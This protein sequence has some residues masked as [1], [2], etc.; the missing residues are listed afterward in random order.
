MSDENETVVVERGAD[1]ALVVRARDV[2]LRV[3]RQAD[4]GLRSVELLLAGLGS[5]MLGTMLAFAENVGVPVD[6]VRIELTP[7][8]ADGPERVSRIDMRLRVEGDID[9]KRL[10]SLQRVAQHCKVHSTLDRRPELTLTFES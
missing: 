10:A 1:G 2:T 7:T 8:I 6:A 4:D 3:G 5:C 9:P